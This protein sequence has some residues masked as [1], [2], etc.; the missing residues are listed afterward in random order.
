MTNAIDAI[1]SEGLIEVT[2]RQVDSFINI[3]I[4]DNGPGISED[5]QKKVLTRSLPPKK[6]VREQA[7]ACGSVMISLKKW[8][9]ISVS[10]ARW[11]KGRRLQ[12][13]LPV[14]TPEKK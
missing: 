12:L 8:V 11:E 13:R 9:G 1:G 4:T 10:V 2:S 14:I 5:R 6:L 3:D 7:S